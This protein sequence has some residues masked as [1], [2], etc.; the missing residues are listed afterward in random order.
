[1]KALASWIINSVVMVLTY[2][3]SHIMLNTI[4]S[5]ILSSTKA[6]LSK[7]YKGSKVSGMINSDGNYPRDMGPDLLQ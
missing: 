3:T 5:I 7:L 4:K 2:H 1:M 6:E